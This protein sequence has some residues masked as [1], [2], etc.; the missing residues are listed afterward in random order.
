[1]PADED[2]LAVVSEWIYRAE[3][4][5]KNAAHV[6]KL[7]RQ[8]P[9][10][11]V[12]FHAQQCV[13]KYIKAA[14]TFYEIDFPKVHDIEKLVRL[15]PA[16][17]LAF[18]PVT[19]QRTLTSYA[20]TARYPGDFDPISLDEARKAVQIARRIRA[21]LRKLLPRVVRRKRTNYQ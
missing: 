6:L 11:T 1:M 18:F 12:A 16:D 15:L 5:L 14:L 10:E 17:A 3:G 4:D 19:E 21:E 8:C 20:V 7:Q 9:T 13:E 2:L